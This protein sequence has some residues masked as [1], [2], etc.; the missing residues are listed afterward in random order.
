MILN[1]S[2]KITIN[3]I[4]NNNNNKI[5]M[6][7][8]CKNC[9]HECKTKKAFDKHI[10]TEKHKRNTANKKKKICYNCSICSKV[11]RLKLNYDKHMIT[12]GENI[13]VHLHAAGITDTQV[14]TVLATLN[15]N[16]LAS[17]ANINDLNSV[18]TAIT[19]QNNIDTQNNNINTQNNQNAAT[20]NNVTNIYITPFG[21]EDISMIPQEKCREIIS[22]E[23]RAYE[24]LIKEMYKHNTNHN[25]FISDKRNK[26]V[27]YLKDDNTLTVAQLYDAL[28]KMIENHKKILNQFIDTFADTFMGNVPAR[29]H[30]LKDDH[31]CG[32]RDDKY[33]IISKKKLYEISES[34]KAL[35]KKM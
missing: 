29:L 31:E 6:Y 3:I 7:F 22:H 32:E 35:I 23:K 24:Y 8:F 18:S 33:M 10:I 5:T 15:N 17:S 30:D 9:K 13:K 12:C 20:I 4:I 28:T 26:L 27:K 2:L 21:K 19:T 1:S 25:I 14:S 11:Y 16:T 34:A